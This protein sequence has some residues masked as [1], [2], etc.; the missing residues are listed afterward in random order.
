MKIIRAV[1]LLFAVHL[2]I[3][4]TEEGENVSQTDPYSN[5][6]NK[7]VISKEKATIW[8]RN[9]GHYGIRDN[10]LRL[11]SWGGIDS[12]RDDLQKIVDLPVGTQFEVGSIRHKVVNTEIG[13]TDAII[14]LCTIRL[15]DE[16]EIEFD[17]SWAAL[18][19]YWHSGKEGR[20]EIIHE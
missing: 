5:W 11:E 13:G 8:R 14:A 16:R 1:I 6:A 9:E 15:E 17:V 10:F 3:A 2:L 18:D 20:F 12:Y 4:C 7:K 19:P